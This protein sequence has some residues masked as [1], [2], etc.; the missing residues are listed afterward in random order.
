[1]L[2]SLDTKSGFRILSVTVI[3][4]QGVLFV[5]TCQMPHHACPGRVARDR[6]PIPNPFYMFSY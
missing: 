5:A 3:V 4:A 6:M 1:M 2:R